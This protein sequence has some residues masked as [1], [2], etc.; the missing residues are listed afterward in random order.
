M[1]YLILGK[2]ASGKT[3]ILNKLMQ[4]K[5][6]ASKV[7]ELK[8]HTTRPIRPNEENGREYIFDTREQFNDYFR[9]DDI[10]EYAVYYTYKGT[11]VYYTLK[12]DLVDDANMIKII[13]P[14]GFCQIRQSVKDIKSVYIDVSD[15]ERLRRLVVRGDDETEVRDR[16]ERDE[17]DFK[18]IKTDYVINGE[19]SED[20][21]INE[22]KNIILRG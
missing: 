21:I 4:D 8:S 5:D 22:I 12:S 14:V 20:E 10:L 9:R 13:N 3:T 2:S 18:Y 7:V 17:E 19:K 1:L 11:W 6:F 15:E 16:F